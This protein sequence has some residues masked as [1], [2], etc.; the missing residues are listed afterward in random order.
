[1]PDAGRSS[2]RFLNPVELFITKENIY[3]FKFLKQFIEIFDIYNRTYSFNSFINKIKY[4][5]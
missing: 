5:N 4:Q 1:M 2:V 3:Y